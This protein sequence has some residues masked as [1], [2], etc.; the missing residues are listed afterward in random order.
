[1]GLPAVA[2]G[3]QAASGVA[4]A[5]AAKK[6]GRAEKAQADKNAYIGETRAL[7]TEAAARENLG[8]ELSSARTVFAANGQRPTSATFDILQEIRSVRDRERRIAVSNELQGADDYRAAGENAMTRA[9]AK[10]IGGYTQAAG[11]IFDLAQIL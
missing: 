4:K 9:R 1:M 11:S 7:Q 8:S 6:A 3:F 2:L 10:A 5:S